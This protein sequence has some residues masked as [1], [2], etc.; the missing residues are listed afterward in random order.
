M[1]ID[2]ACSGTLYGVDVAC[3]YL[4]TGQ[5]N[6]AI[7]AGANLFLN[8]DHQID[9]RYALGD[10]PLTRTGACFTFDSRADGY[11]K[12]EGV[13]MVYLKRLDDAIR[14]GDPIRAVIRGSSMTSDGWTAGIMSPDS[15]AQAETIL[16]AYKNAGIS[17]LSETSYIEC[18]GTGTKAGDVIEVNGVASVFGNIERKGPLRIG[19]VSLK[20]SRFTKIHATYIFSG[21]EQYWTL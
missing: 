7:V 2:T 16:Q 17:D 12:A 5:I 15:K 1:T 13:N 8:P 18:H 20:V 4:H 6:G 21:Q 9:R 11:I 19:S 10:V 3:K 14:D